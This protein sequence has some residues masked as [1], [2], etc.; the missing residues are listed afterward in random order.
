MHY[1]QGLL[2]ILFSILLVTGCEPLGE[3]TNLTDEPLLLTEESY[4]E[5]AVFFCGTNDVEVVNGYFEDEYEPDTAPN[6]TFD[7]WKADFLNRD[8]RWGMI[9]LNGGSDD[10]GIC[11]EGGY[12]TTDKAW[13]ASWEDHKDR[14]GPTRNSV[15]IDIAVGEIAVKG[16]HFFNVHDGVR[17][18]DE[19]SNWLVENVWG[20]YVRDD[21]IENDHVLS[22]RVQDTLFDGCYTGISTRPSSSDEDLDGSREVVTLDSVLLRLQATPYPYKWD[23]KDDALDAVGNPYSGVG[24]PYGHGNFFKM[25][26][27]DK[28]PHFAITNSVFLAYHQ[29]EPD[30]FDFPAEELIDQCENNTIVWLG[31]GEYPGKLPTDKFPGCFTIL[32][33]DEGCDFWEAKVLDWHTRNPQVGADRKPD[34]PGNLDF[35]KF[36]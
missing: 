18:S 16:L 31:P 27:V 17:F 36:F 5:P 7:A 9:T 33:G 8:V 29:N 3:S 26:E 23:E 11:W 30:K 34:H 12:V 32:T 25:H 14:E 2:W 21:C 1:H 4:V 20:D 24:V 35:P 19:A 15:A 28:N 10:K 6:M 22:G 13:D